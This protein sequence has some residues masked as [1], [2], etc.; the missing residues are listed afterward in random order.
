[1]PMQRMME[2]PYDNVKAASGT[3]HSYSHV[4]P[5][6]AKLQSPGTSLRCWNIHLQTSHSLQYQRY[7]QEHV[8]DN[9]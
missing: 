5:S 6:H 1:M 9:N 2:Y 4:L 8:P 3:L 7:A